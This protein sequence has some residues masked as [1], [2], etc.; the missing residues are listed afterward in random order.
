MKELETA[1]LI[2]IDRI[3]GE[4]FQKGLLCVPGRIGYWSTRFSNIYT[5]LFFS[6]LMGLDLTVVIFLLKCG[7]HGNMLLN[8]LGSIQ[9]H[10]EPNFSVPARRVLSFPNNSQNWV[11]LGTGL[12]KQKKDV[13]VWKFSLDISEN[14]HGSEC[15]FKK[16]SLLQIIPPAMN[17]FQ[18]VILF[19]SVG[20]VTPLFHTLR[21]NLKKKI[22]EGCEAQS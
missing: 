18:P 4:I 1:I 9:S 15:T 22:A 3:G 14:F 7:L 20:K 21:T 2:R 8:I 17:L 16:S 11:F 6:N 19:H 13:A 12:L 5:L 10:D